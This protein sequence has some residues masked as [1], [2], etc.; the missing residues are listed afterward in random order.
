[1]TIGSNTIRAG[2]HHF[3]GHAKTWDV[4]ESG[5]SCEFVPE[6]AMDEET[7]IWNVSLGCLVK[8]G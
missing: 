7:I 3:L 6:F 5:S 1:M 8:S 2:N 4:V